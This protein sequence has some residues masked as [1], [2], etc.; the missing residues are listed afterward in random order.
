MFEVNHRTGRTFLSGY[1][2]TD[3]HGNAYFITVYPGWYQG[4]A[5]HIHAK[6]RTF[7]GAS[8]TYEF[9]SHFFM[10]D[11]FT[12]EVYRLAPYNT[13]GISFGPHHAAH[14]SDPGSEGAL[15]IS[16]GAI[17]PHFGKPADERFGNSRRAFL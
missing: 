7:N 2:P 9:T 13:R 17:S 3:R 10:D 11:A 1:Q 14:G 4:R 8:Q 15:R 16:R 12:G 6:V 5:V